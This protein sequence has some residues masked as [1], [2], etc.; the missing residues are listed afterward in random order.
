MGFFLKFKFEMFWKSPLENTRIELDCEII[1][2]GK[3]F[4]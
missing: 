2:R 3:D 4:S 1:V